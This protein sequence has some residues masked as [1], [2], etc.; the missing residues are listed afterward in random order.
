WFTG[1]V[2][3]HVEETDEMLF[4]CASVPDWSYP[5]LEWHD[6]IEEIYCIAGDIWLGNSGVM[7]PG[8]YL[9]RPP[10]ITHGPF[11]SEDGSIL[12]CWVSET[13]VNHIPDGP[14]TTPEENR[15]S[16]VSA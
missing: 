10:Y 1:K 6:C 5:R 14:T 15:R 16:A 11:R 7:R 12:L 4:L 2:L 8:S 9:W 3:R 13:L